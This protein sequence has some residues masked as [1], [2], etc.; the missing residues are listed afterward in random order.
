MLCYQSK[1]SLK[2]FLTDTGF[3][4]F[5]SHLFLPRFLFS[6]QVP[7]RKQ[8]NLFIYQKGLGYY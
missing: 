3:L 2:W 6:I 4:Q 7:M 1:T 5:T 8:K